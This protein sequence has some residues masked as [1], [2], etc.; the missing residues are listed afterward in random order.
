MNFWG[1]VI[2]RKICIIAMSLSTTGRP[3][4]RQVV[5]K[6]DGRAFS[7]HTVVPGATASI[8]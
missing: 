6:A 2:Q 5:S 4:I 8:S 1:S 3:D 7:P